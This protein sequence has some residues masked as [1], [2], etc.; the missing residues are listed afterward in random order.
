MRHLCSGETKTK[1]KLH[2]DWFREPRI[3]FPALS[4]VSTNKIGGFV[5]IYFQ[6]VLI[7]TT[8]FASLYD[9][10][11]IALKVNVQFY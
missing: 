11:K 3:V 10:N 4:F 7:W 6:F 9:Y 2:S 1:F 5:C 8:Q